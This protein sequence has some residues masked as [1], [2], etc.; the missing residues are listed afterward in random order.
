MSQLDTLLSRV[1]Y[2]DEAKPLTAV[3]GAVKKTSQANKFPQKRTCRV[4]P[5]NRVERG[6]FT[7]LDTR[8]VAQWKRQGNRTRSSFRT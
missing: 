2:E 4:K 3:E 1:V 6:A 5:Q 8:N 7:E